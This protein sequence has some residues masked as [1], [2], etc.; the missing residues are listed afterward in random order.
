MSFFDDLFGGGA[1]KRAAEKNRGLYTNLQNLGSGYLQQGY[2]TG[3]SN[4]NQAK[5]AFTP[6]SALGEKYGGA[7]TMLLNALGVNGAAG[8][9]AA[10]NAFQQAPGYQFTLDQ[11][12]ESINRRRAAAGMLN[13]GNAD[14]DAIK[15]AT[16]LADQ[17]YGNW[18]SNLGQFVSPELSA[19]SGAASGKAGAFGDLASLAQNNS[20]NQ[21]GLLNQTTAGQVGANNLQAEGEAAGA[22][23]LL[24]L[25]TS[26]A[27][28]G[29]GGLFGG[30]GSSL[31]GMGLGFG[32]AKNTTG[33]LY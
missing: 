17:T 7:S 4:L 19:T 27:S 10:T 21:L 23:N 9:Q 6:L 5:D 29:T 20:M 11:G 33:R 2:D 8:S 14:V 3:V 25:G 16:G 13:S 12:L 31:G 15:Y 1:E 30:F 24:G 22:K 32:S 18:L 26:L 28:L